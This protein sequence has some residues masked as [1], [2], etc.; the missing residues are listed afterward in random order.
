MS[1]P[2]LTKKQARTCKSVQKIIKTRFFVDNHEILL[3]FS[4]IDI[5]SSS[6]RL[7]AGKESGLNEQVE[8][9]QL[10]KC[11]YVAQELKT[12]IIA[13]KYRSGDQL[14]P[15]PALCEMFSVSRITVR[16][17]LKK[18][19]M[20][21]LVEIKQ[22]KGTFVKSVDLGLFMK[23]MLQLVDFDEIDIETIYSAREYIEGGIAYLAA[24]QRTDG[25][26]AILESILGKL[27][28]AIQAGD[29][30]SS[31]EY[32]R[33]FHD[34]LARAAHN[35]ILFACLQTI[36][37]INEACVK[38]YDKFLIMLD[39]CYNEHF[40]IFTAVANQQPEKAQAA[41]AQQRQQARFA[42]MRQAVNTQRQAFDDYQRAAQARS[43]AQWAADR[44]RS[45][46]AASDSTWTDGFSDAM[47]GVNTWVRPDGTEVETS[48]ASNRAWTN[49]AGDVVGGGGGFDPGAD[50]TELHQK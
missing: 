6:E 1:R 11:D 43:D 41:M 30:L 21:G 35:P 27:K 38:R 24:Q 22:G 29:I 28:A 44:A 2:H 19:S 10:S 25:E 50:W 13:G 48:T 33:A 40:Q 32:D 47:R 15:E 8:R 7:A 14:P 9:R 26:L 36:E 20:M 39:D 37:E 46:H 12:Q 45:G 17:A 16:E 42:A 23:P 4:F 49:A 34:D 18:L 31:N 5:I 3:Y